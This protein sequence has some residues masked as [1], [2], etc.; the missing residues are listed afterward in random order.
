MTKH[1]TEQN[2][3][4]NYRTLRYAYFCYNY[5]N[6]QIVVKAINHFYT[7]VKFEIIKIAFS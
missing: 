4:N 3:K 6:P 5:S 2:N 7:F 1:T